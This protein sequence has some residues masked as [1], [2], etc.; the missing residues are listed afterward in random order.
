MMPGGLQQSAADGSAVPQLS[1]QMNQ[2]Q[3]NQ[4]SVCHAELLLR[5]NAYMLLVA[6]WLYF[7]FVSNIVFLHIPLCVL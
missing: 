3:L 6:H 7:Y 1:S 2:L 4:P 5:C